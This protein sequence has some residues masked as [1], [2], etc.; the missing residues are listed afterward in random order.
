MKSEVYKTYTLSKQY[1]VLNKKPFFNIINE[2]SIQLYAD[3]FNRKNTLPS[4]ED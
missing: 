2:S 3:L 1:K 4:I